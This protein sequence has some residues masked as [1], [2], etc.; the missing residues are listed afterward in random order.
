MNLSAITGTT[1]RGGIATETYEF[2]S[3]DIHVEAVACPYRF[4]KSI[5]CRSLCKEYVSLQY[6]LDEM[7]ETWESLI[8]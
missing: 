3:R 5:W 2:T 7:D 1:K 6:T 8:T 4:L